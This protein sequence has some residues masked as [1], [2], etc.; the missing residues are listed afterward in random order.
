MRQINYFLLL[1]LGILIACSST[2]KNHKVAAIK[3]GVEGYI[4][5]VSGNRMPAPNAP[6]A[7][8]VG[9]S[10]TV[11]VYE[12]TNVKDVV[13]IDVSPTYTTINKKLIATTQSDSTGRFAIALPVGRYSLFVKENGFFYSN[14]FDVDN[15]IAPFTVEEN[16]RTKMNLVISS[17]A[18][19]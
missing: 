13:R 10:A 3:Q 11:Y 5:R 17:S 7:S 18:T 8:P 16:K 9:I 19:F 2:R 15:N 4:Q 12:L 6:A 1:L 14:L